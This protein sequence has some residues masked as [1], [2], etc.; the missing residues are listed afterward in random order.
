[1]FTGNKTLNWHAQIFHL[2]QSHETRLLYEHTL[3]CMYFDDR[4]F[5]LQIV[6]L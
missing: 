2:L 5:D 6:G 3:Q 1:M 4:H